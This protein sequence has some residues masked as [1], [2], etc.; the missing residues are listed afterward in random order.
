MGLF[1][2]NEKDWKERLGDEDKAVLMEIECLYY[3]L[4]KFE[5]E[6]KIL[7]CNITSKFTEKNKLLLY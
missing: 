3:F 7:N 4:Y 2:R 5:E 1:K 6:T